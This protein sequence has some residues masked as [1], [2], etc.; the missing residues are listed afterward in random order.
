MAKKSIFDTGDFMSGYYASKEGDGREMT[1]GH[2]GV[3]DTKGYD[4]FR[5]L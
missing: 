1:Y 3:T 2:P 4:L 5:S